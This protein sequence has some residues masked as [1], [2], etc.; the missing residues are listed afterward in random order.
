ME[1]KPLKKAR[2]GMYVF[3]GYPNAHNQ[4]PWHD[5]HSPNYGTNRLVDVLNVDTSGFDYRMMAGH[6]YGRFENGRMSVK[7]R[8]E[9]GEFEGYIKAEEMDGDVYEVLSL[10][11]EEVLQWHVDE[12]IRKYSDNV[13]ASCPSLD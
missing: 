9:N 1:V 7:K 5:D 3:I 13:S 8:L 6:H 11:P 2:T 12:Y 10:E 4:G